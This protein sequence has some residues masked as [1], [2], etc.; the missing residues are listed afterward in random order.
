MNIKRIII[1]PFLLISISFT[2]SLILYSLQWSTI[3]PPLTFYNLIPIITFIILNI[4]ASFL[5]DFFKLY[6]VKLNIFSKR[7]SAAYNFISAFA[8]LLTC[9]EML[10][11]GIPLLGQV[12]YTDFG[13]PILHVIV[14]SIFH[15]GA[16]YHSISY[17]TSKH[18]KNMYYL[19]IFFIVSLLIMNRF[20][21]LYMAIAIMFVY[22]CNSGVSIGKFLKLI[23]LSILLLILFGEIGIF[24]MSMITNLSYEHARLY[25]LDA[26]YASVE[27][28]E[29]GL[30]TSFYWIWLYITSPL[31]NLIY[32]IDIS[33]GHSLMKMSNV[34]VQ[35]IL[36]ETFSKR[37]IPALGLNVVDVKLIVPHLNVSTA[38][39]R[40]YNSSGLV[41]IISFYLY[42]TILFFYL[43]LTFKG[44][45]RT[46]LN[47]FMSIMCLFLMFHNILKMPIFLFSVAIVVCT[48]LRVRNSY[49][50]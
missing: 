14:I 46:I 42:Y 49:G 38:L 12:A 5:W 6:D 7:D 30:P 23:L 22:I 28:K 48:K 17:M 9:I 18:S 21:M 50:K 27:Y 26:G 11:Y 16:I 40:I 24:R 1:N 45:V 13:A 29:Y 19:I 2:L 33:Q 43:N 3:F 36:P 35:E 4:L 15:V 10:I 41:G 20:L 8:L 37:L 25:I 44:S 32:N 39:A 34:I 47:I 31:S